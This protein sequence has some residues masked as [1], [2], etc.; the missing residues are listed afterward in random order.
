MDQD[1]EERVPAGFRRTTPIARVARGFRVAS[2]ARPQPRHRIARR[3]LTP[4]RWGARWS[5]WRGRAASARRMAGRSAGWV[6]L[7]ETSV[8][9]RKATVGARTLARMAIEE[10]TGSH[11]VPFQGVHGA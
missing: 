2:P 1:Y 6:P 7:R 3:D 8:I 9:M 5:R 4:G 10:M 11:K